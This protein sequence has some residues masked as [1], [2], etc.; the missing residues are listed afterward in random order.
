MRDADLANGQDRGH[1]A[2]RSDLDYASGEFS[3]AVG[4]P[5]QIDLV[6]APDL[7]DIEQKQLW[8]VYANGVSIVGIHACALHAR[9]QM[10]AFSP[11]AL[12]PDR[13]AALQNKTQNVIFRAYRVPEEKGDRVAIAGW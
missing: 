8:I 4:N 1:L 10:Q 6:L 3:P 12:V 9:G 11:V 13:R 7:F 2:H 5:G